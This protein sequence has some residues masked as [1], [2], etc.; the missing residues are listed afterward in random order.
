MITGI[1]LIL[2][3]IRVA[4]GA[5]LTLEAGR[6]ALPRPCDR[7]PHQCREPGVVPAL[8]RQDRALSRARRAW[9]AH[10]FSGVSGLHDPALLRLA[11]RQADRARQD[12]RRMP[13]AA[14]PLRSTNSWSTGS[15]PRCRCSA[16]WCATRPS[17]TATTTSTGWSS[18]SR[19]AEWTRESPSAFAGWAY[20]ACYRS[21]VISRRSAPGSGRPD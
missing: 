1:D 3:Q 18:F 20:S 12:A 8:A 11:G 9:R 16:R 15:T 21:V 4:A 2:E 5:E 19:A 10:R 13:D 17:S 7:V 14:A 6:R